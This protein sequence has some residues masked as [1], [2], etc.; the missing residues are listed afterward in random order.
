MSCLAHYGLNVLN[1]VLFVGPN[2]F[3][4]FNNVWTIDECTWIVGITIKLF[5]KKVINF[6]DKQNFHFLRLSFIF[7]F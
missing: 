4:Y 7:R 6:V 1:I 5:T 2:K 3:D